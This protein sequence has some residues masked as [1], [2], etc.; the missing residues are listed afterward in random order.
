[1]MMGRDI[2][3]ALTLGTNDA[4]DTSFSRWPTSNYLQAVCRK[5]PPRVKTGDPTE[6]GDRGC[7]DSDLVIVTP[8]LQHCQEH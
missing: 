5:F 6:F 1:M 8:A 7:L 3:S 4:A 2:V